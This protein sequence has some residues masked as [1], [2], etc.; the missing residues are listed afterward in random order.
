MSDQ[1]FED[2]ATFYGNKLSEISSDVQELRQLL[3]KAQSIIDSSW[4]G[5][6]A[7]AA[8]DRVGFT[9][10][11]LAK[12]DSELNEALASLSGIPVDGDIL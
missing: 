8:E 9:Q 6:S 5:K 7:T 4:K 1:L 3:I 10:A 11:E 12:V 2:A